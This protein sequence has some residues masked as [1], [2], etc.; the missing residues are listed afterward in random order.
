M[1]TW[2]HRASHQLQTCRFLSPQGCFLTQLPEQYTLMSHI[3]SPSW[4]FLNP[5]FSD[6]LGQNRTLWLWEAH[7]VP[8]L[9]HLVGLEADFG[10][11]SQRGLFL[12]SECTVRPPR[13]PEHKLGA[14]LDL[15]SGWVSEEIHRK[16]DCLLGIDT[17]TVRSNRP[18]RSFKMRIRR[19]KAQPQSS[20]D[21]SR[22]LMTESLTKKEVI[23]QNRASGKSQ[24]QSYT[25]F[26][27]LSIRF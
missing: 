23:E 4:P 11:L 1:H 21:L 17:I 5:D 25:T 27:S 14:C 13:C 22:F 19:S 20:D 18:E 16:L 3:L 8:F 7:L 10:A 26:S 2:A 12:K 6:V 9:P 15:W 24:F